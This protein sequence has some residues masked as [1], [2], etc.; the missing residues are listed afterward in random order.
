MMQKSQQNTSKQNS[1][2]EQKDCNHDQVGF[3]ANMQGCST[4]KSQPM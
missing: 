4:D 1:A 3:I 2:A